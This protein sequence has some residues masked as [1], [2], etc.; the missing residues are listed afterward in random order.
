[1]SSFDLDNSFV[2]LCHFSKFA[3]KFKDDEPGNISTELFLY[4][5]IIDKVVHDTLP[6]VAITIR[7]CLV[8]MVTDCSA[9]RSLSK[10]KLIEN[11]R[12]SMTEG[13]L[14]NLAIVSMSQTFCVSYYHYRR[15]C[16]CKI[17]KGKKESK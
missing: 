7:M 1:M 6:N 17:E 14:V 13:R 12:T 10:L 9:E 4:K 3:D 5:L 16:C 8:L 15:I 11:D 2:E